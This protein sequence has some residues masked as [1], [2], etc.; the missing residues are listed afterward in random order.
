MVVN[1]VHDLGSLGVGIWPLFCIEV[2]EEV[3]M[4]KKY[5]GLGKFGPVRD[6][7]RVGPP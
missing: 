6:S 3:H 1:V 2:L 4:S 7:S 5:F